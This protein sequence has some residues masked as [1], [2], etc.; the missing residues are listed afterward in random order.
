VCPCI[1]STLAR[2]QGCQLVGIQ[3]DSEQ[4]VAETGLARLFAQ[5]HW[6]LGYQCPWRG[7]LRT[8]TC[9]RR[10]ATMAGGEGGEREW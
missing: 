8:R 3:Q 9:M 4:Q 10:E 1:G 7:I 6:D 2:P 5:S